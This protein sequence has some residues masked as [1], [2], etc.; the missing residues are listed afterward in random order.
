MTDQ[1]LRRTDELLTELVELVETARTVPMSSS[2]VLPRERVLDLLDEL[3]ETMPP[4]MQE[5]RHTIANRDT[6][7]HEAYAEAKHARETA[8]AEAA[9]DA[10]PTP[11]SVPTSRCTRPTCTH[12]RSSRPAGLNTLTWSRRPASTR[13]PPRQRTSCA[14]EA[15]RDCDAATSQAQA[16]ANQVRSE[17]DAY[18]AK[19]TADAEDYADR[20]LAEL[21]ADAAAQRR[22]GRAGPRRPGQRGRGATGAGFVRAKRRDFGLIRHLG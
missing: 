15:R 10:R 1:A 16:H 14:T 9:G 4:E 3:R 6:L 11:V 5:A 2:I 8:A 13:P 21:V 22:D 19:L 18:A 20:T 12:T 7:L 17:A